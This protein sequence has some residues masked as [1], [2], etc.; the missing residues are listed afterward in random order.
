MSVDSNLCTSDVEKLLDAFES[1]ISRI[2]K[3][4][5]RIE[6]LIRD[7]ATGSSL[8]RRTELRR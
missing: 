1:S 4:L 5:D 6:Q 7:Y 2:E 8:G 3:R